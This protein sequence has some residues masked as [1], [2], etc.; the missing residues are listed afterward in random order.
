[1]RRI[2]SSIAL[3]VTL[4]GIN[5]ARAWQ[6]Q[7]GAAPKTLDKP[8]PAGVVEE[9]LP[10]SSPK[11]AA[12]G[13][14]WRFLR[15]QG[16][17][18]YWL[19]SEKWVYWSDGKWVPYDPASYAQLNASRRARNYSYSGRGESDFWGPH[20]YDS[21]GNAQPPYSQR[22]R[23]IKQLGPVPA[24]GGVRSLPGWGGER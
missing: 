23:G 12:A 16:L 6:S 10:E 18:W 2:Q 19:P 9:K 24:M 17:W 4:A 3:V 14:S 7:E 5:T 21:Y 8:A 11:P 13:D 20:R 1:M 22:T 15:H